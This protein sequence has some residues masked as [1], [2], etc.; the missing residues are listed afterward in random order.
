MSARARPAPAIAP[1]ARDWSTRPRPSPPS[2]ADGVQTAVGSRP[3]ARAPCRSVS[4]TTGQRP[5]SLLLLIE[6]D[7]QGVQPPRPETA[8]GRQP[9]IDFRQP[10]RPQPVA[11]M[12]LV[13]PRG[14]QVRIP[15]H[16]QMLGD[17]WLTQRKALDQLVDAAFTLAQLVQN[18]AAVRLGEDGEG[19]LHTASMPDRLYA[20]QGTLQRL[21]Y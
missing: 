14:H 4:G 7:L 18:A 5:G 15:Q 2:G 17:G 6:M 13:D 12:L 1:A 21:V 3:R 19:R 8:V 20:C 16:A 9:G 11:A 10:L